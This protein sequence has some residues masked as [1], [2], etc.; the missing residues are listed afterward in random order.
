MGSLRLVP[1]PSKYEEIPIACYVAGGFSSKCD[2]DLEREA[3]RYANGCEGETISQGNGRLAYA[4][5]QTGDD[6]LAKGPCLCG[7]CPWA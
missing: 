3:Y 1:V 6:E 2:N 7:S 4:M 5:F